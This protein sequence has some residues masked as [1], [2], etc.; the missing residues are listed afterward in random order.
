M[1]P[2]EEP[3]PMLDHVGA[4]LI[5]ARWL[6]TFTF[7]AH[8]G[9]SFRWTEKGLRRVLLLWH[10]IGE[11]DLDQEPTRV[12]RFTRECQNP[13]ISQDRSSNATCAFRD[14]W[15]ACLEELRL[16]DE[17]D[18]WWAFVLIANAG[19]QEKTG[20]K[21]HSGIARLHLDDIYLPHAGERPN[22]FERQWIYG[23]C[24]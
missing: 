23:S 6:D 14:Y 13:Q 22:L 7:V 9:Y 16:D 15:L 11:Y 19:I 3:I 10:I 18:Y 20:S 1:N 17:E 21:R 2:H 5:E 4:R 12:D 24:Q 8:Q